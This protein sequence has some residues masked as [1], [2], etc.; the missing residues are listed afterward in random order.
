M[1]EFGPLER[2][3]MDV[4]WDAAEPVT[5]RTVTEALEHRGLAY[6]TI[7]TVLQK[8]YDKGWLR[9]ERIGRVWF[10]RAAV[11]RTDYA[12]RVMHEALHESGGT[13]TTLLRFVDAMSDEEARM[14]RDLLAEEGEESR[15]DSGEDRDVGRG[16]DR[17]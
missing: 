17:P 1:G 13:R 14:L 5:V 11:G 2:A 15:T 16:G 8:L 7:S 4:V 6:T 3:V 12:A 9:R 10:Y